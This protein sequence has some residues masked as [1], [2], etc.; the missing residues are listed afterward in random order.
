MLP[1]LLLEFVE[2]PDRLEHDVGRGVQEDRVLDE[3]EAGGP[4]RTRPPQADAAGLP[5]TGGRG[6]GGDE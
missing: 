3:M 5:L 4:C 2:V 6:V 1:V